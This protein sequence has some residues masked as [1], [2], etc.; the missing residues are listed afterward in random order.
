MIL[1]YKF[2]ALLRA[3]F[4]TGSLK[5]CE[6]SFHCFKSSSLWWFATAALGNEYSFFYSLCWLK[7]LQVTIPQIVI[8]NFAIE[9]SDF[10]FHICCILV[11]ALKIVTSSYTF[12]KHQI[13]HF[14]IIF[15]FNYVFIKWFSDVARWVAY[16]LLCILYRNQLD[17][18]PNW[19][20]QM[21]LGIILNIWRMIATSNL[22]AF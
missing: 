6:T 4:Q 3:W 5:N 12:Q 16:L 1:P 20:T 9:K 7:G 18:S 17:F 14:I 10:R 8:A 11:S 22:N 13:N 21:S 15:L 19:Y 2:H